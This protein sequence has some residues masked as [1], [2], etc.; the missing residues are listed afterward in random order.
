VQ[1]IPSSQSLTHNAAGRLT[2]VSGDAGTSS[3]RYD[4]RGNLTSAT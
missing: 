2:A 3:W 1:G 4:G